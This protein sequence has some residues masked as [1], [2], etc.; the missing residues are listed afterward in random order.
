MCELLNKG[1]LIMKAELSKRYCVTEKT[2]QRDIDD[3]RAYL[4]DTHFAKG[5]VSIQYDKSIMGK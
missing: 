3:L 1:E 5:E 2:I 4:A